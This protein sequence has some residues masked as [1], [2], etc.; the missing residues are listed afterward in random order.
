MAS[1]PHSILSKRAAGALLHITSLSGGHGIGDLGK[2]AYQFVDWLQQAGL[3][4]WQ[5]LPLVPPGSGFSPYS[6]WSSMA[7]NTLLID[8]EDLVAMGILS[9]EDLQHAPENTSQVHPTEVTRFKQGHLAKAVSNFLASASP[10]LKSEYQHFIEANPWAP[11]SA[12][13]LALKKKHTGV[14]NSWP[15]TD[16]N[17]DAQRLSELLTENGEHIETECLSQFLLERQ[18]Q[19][20]RSYANKQGIQLIGDLPIYVDLDSVDVWLNQGLFQLDDTGRPTQVSGVPPDNFSVTGQLWG[21]PIYDWQAHDAQGYAWWKQ[22]LARCFAQTDF[23]RIDHFRGFSAYWSVPFG[24][25]DATNGKW[26]QGPGEALFQSLRST[27]KDDL[28][29]IAEDLGDIDQA[30]H[31]LKRK[32]GLPGMCVLQFGFADNE[33]L[34]HHPNHH[35]E[36]SVC[37]TGTHDNETSVQWRGHLS[38]ENSKVLAEFFPHNSLSDREF[39]WK[40]IDLLFSSKSLVSIAPMQDFLALGEEA[41]MN[42]PSTVEKNWL[43]RLKEGQTT[44][45]L[46]A[47]IRGRLEQHGRR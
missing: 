40:F 29:V 3:K 47:E 8:L 41:R 42:F 12:L 28:K 18:W 34:I 23:V 5:I 33:D 38:E 43:W 10:E 46:A 27:F 11:Q 44:M 36:F 7:M 39:A 6:T 14:W 1:N 37:Y 19:K 21:H 20:L 26:V 24:S 25:Q 32:A 17:P 13:Y 22:R 15:E 4:Y 31:D 16:R 9:Q 2:S 35:P 30:V 45:N